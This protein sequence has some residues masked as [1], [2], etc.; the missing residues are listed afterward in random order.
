MVLMI[1]FN[2]VTFC[3]IIW[4]DDN[5]YFSG[6]L[7]R[8]VQQDTFRKKKKVSRVRYTVA[9]LLITY[10]VND[11]RTENSSY[12]L[13]SHDLTP[14]VLQAVGIRLRA[15]K[16]RPKFTNKIVVIEISHKIS[17]ELTVNV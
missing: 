9:V 6:K 16:V 17:I 14:E 4:L 15:T 11:H 5:I 1:T 7:A 12:W 10:V 8:G 13:G 3:V 2:A